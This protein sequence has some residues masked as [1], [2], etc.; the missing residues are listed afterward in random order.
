M[1]VNK[2]VLLAKNYI[3]RKKR[4]YKTLIFFMIISIILGILFYFLISGKDK[5]VVVNSIKNFF[6]E[7]K[8]GDNLNYGLSLINALLVNIGYVLLIWLLGISVIGLPLIVLIMFYKCFITGFSISAIINVYGFKGILGAFLY[9]FPHGIIFLVVLLLLGTYSI[10]F[11]LRLFNYLFRKKLV[12]F[13]DI[14]NKYIK[15][16]VISLVSAIVLAFI[17]V[18]VSTYF[19]KLFTY[20]IK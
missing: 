5:I 16:L 8:K 4:E 7:I 3:K 2:N 14:M 9:T 15:I 20:L 18:F 17:E 6:S 11:S 10:S 19:I 13:K 12:N 1:K